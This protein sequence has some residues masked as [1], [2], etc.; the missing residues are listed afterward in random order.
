MVVEWSISGHILYE[1]IFSFWQVKE[2]YILLP[3][4]FMKIFKV[5]IGRA[6]SKKQQIPTGGSVKIWQDAECKKKSIF[7]AHFVTYQV[8]HNSVMV[9][10]ILQ[11]PRLPLAPMTHIPSSMIKIIINLVDRPS[12]STVTNSCQKTWQ[13]R[14]KL[15]LA[16]MTHI[17]SSMMKIVINLVDRSSFST[18]TYSCQKT[19]HC[20]QNCHLLVWPIYQAQWW[21]L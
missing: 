13:P 15:P 8:S 2:R 1:I 6:L 3:S 11:H 10:P 12:K 5:P 17:P 9:T 7:Q 20:T 18:V 21:K 16:P 19:G 4:I 14:M